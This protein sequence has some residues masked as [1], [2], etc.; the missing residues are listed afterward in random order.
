MTFKDIFLTICR[1]RG[2]ITE[3]E[4]LNIYDSK[5]IGQ[6]RIILEKENELIESAVIISLLDKYKSKIMMEYEKVP[7][8]ARIEAFNESINSQITA[9]NAIRAASGKF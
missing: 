6:S 5:P 1:D 7:N 4:L 8:Q 3:K 9:F 2:I